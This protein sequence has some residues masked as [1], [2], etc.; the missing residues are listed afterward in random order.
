MSAAP[1][2]SPP[3]QRLAVFGDLLDFDAAPALDDP[4]SPGV[5]Y[6]PAHWLLI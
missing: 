5:R 2:S 3:P 6:R 4:A 1:L